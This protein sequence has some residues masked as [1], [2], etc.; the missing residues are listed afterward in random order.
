MTPIA[1]AKLVLAA[2]GIAVF[3]YGWQTGQQPVRWIGIGLVF[4][5]VLLRFLRR[6]PRGEPERRGPVAPG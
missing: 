5:A 2:A 6:R 4:A 1:I 3:Y